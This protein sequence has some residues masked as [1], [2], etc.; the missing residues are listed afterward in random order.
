MAQTIATA[1]ST[2]ASSM[3]W[4]VLFSSSALILLLGSSSVWPLCCLDESR[5]VLCVI[6]AGAACLPWGRWV[7]S[8]CSPLRQ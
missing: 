8:Y 7:R 5:I 4:V 3:R 2:S 1:R 6:P